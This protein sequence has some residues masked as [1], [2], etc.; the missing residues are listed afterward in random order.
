MT[1]QHKKKISK[2]LSLILRH[3]PEKIGLALDENGWAMITDILNKSKVRCTFEE[4]VEVVTTNDKQR[5]AL[6]DNQTKIRANQG[7]SIRTIDLDLKSQI[8]P[9]FLY[10][11]TVAKFIPEIK[12]QGLKKMSRQHVH[13]S[14]D[15]DTANKVGSRRGKPIILSVR[16]LDMHNK[17]HRFYKSE[18]GVWLTDK[19]APEFINFKE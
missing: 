9:T 6:N 13:L 16:A 14:M 10:H 15:R 17:G 3:Q 12:L 18:N 7:H 4:L 2:F 19:V 11:G 1:E 5:F 8:P